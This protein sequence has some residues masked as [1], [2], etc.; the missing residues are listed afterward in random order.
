[1]V[2]NILCLVHCTLVVE[3]VVVVVVV[4]VVILVVEVVVAVVV[5]VEK[6]PQNLEAGHIL[7][8]YRRREWRLKDV[9]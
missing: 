1:M 7:D 5:V 4:V 8:L 2:E 6:N 3:V 9:Q